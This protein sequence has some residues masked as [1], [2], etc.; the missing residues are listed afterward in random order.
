MI[1]LVLFLLVCEISHAFV[2]SKGLGWGPF[3][4]NHDVVSTSTT[5]RG[6]TVEE[7]NTNESSNTNEE[8]IAVETN[9]KTADILSLN[10]I[11]STLI[12]QEET[13]IF[14]LIERAQFRQNSKV[15]Q[16][17]GFGDL[18][19]PLGSV[20]TN[21]EE[22]LENSFLDYMLIGTVSFFIDEYTTI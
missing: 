17:G 1:R 8:A 5:A 19:V 2:S 18:G 22:D 10:S 9:L 4:H 16:N 11:R 3:T 20:V 7:T 12:R 21:D 15:Y 14:A 6:A 13:I